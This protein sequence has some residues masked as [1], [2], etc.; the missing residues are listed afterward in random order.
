[1]KKVKILNSLEKSGV[2]AVVRAKDYKST[3][4]YCEALIE[5]GITGLEITFTIPSAQEIIKE[6]SEKY[7]DKKDIIIGAG[8]VLDS[9]TARIAIMAGAKYI[10]SPSFNLETCQVCNLYQIPYLPGCFTMTEIT[11][12]LNAGVDIVKVFPG[13]ACSPS[14]IKS[15]KGPLPY[16][17]IM[18][19]GGV[20]I[21]NMEEWFRNGVTCVGIGGNLLSE[22]INQTRENARLYIEKYNKIK[23]E[24][25]NE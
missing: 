6:L 21:D 10:V 16:L 4:E 18:V 25:K 3:I 8:T 5:G 11:T 23:G 24:S 9:T 12:A 17:N 13:N 15:F 2:I 20:N 1:M 7:K 19:T 14:V 22:D